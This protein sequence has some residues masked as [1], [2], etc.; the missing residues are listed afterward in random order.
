MRND[1]AGTRPQGDKQEMGP[2]DQ[3]DL[4]STPSSNDDKL[5]NLRQ[6]ASPLWPSSLKWGCNYLW[7]YT[8]ASEIMQLKDL[9]VLRAQ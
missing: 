6:V 8:Q 9:D 3:S 5:Y 2:R 7:V 1:K 4:E